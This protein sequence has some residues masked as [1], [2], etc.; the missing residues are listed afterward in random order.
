MV[1]EFVAKIHRANNLV[2][3]KSQPGIASGVAAAVDAA[4][5][6]RE[7]GSVAGNGYGLGRRSHYR[8]RQALCG[9]HQEAA[10]TAQREGL[11]LRYRR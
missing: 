8:G 4:Q 5:P 2:V 1:P 7:V 9:D 10:L 3:I 6:P 11:A